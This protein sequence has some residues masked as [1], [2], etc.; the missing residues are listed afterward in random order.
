MTRPIEQIPVLEIGGTH[1]TAALIAIGQKAPFV[2]EQ[3]RSHLDAHAPAEELVTVLAA[4]AAKLKVTASLPWGVAV[5]GPFNYER[6]IGRFE[7]VGKFDGL[8]DFDLGFA[9]S[10]SILPRPSSVRFLNDADAFGMGECAA[11]AGRRHDRVLCLTLGTGVG[12]AFIDQGVPV[13]EGPEVPPDGSAHL[14]IWRGRPLEETVSRRAIRGRYRQLTGKQL[15]VREI[16]QLA[17]FGEAEATS[18][19][20]AAMLA[21][22][23][24]VAP[25][26]VSFK[27]NVIVVGGS[28]SGSWD[29]LER[30]FRAGLIAACP[31]LSQMDLQVAELP[32]DA[33]LIGAAAFAL[34]VG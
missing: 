27:A 21:L 6:G 5:P 30:P 24:A 31:E 8:N 23:D 9:L 28:I 14:I 20:D 32:E 33:P 2:V 19:I 3:Y 15:D 18:V 16:A 11:G 26:A 29:I 22:G 34:P 4:T 17:R 7:K 1:V 10:E 12:S 13:N 25:W